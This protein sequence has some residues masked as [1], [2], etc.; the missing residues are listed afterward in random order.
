M[1]H[2]ARIRTIFMYQKPTEEQINRMEYLRR[3]C[4]DL[5]LA[6][7][8]HCPPCA[9]RQ[10]AIEHLSLVSMQANA[11]IVRHEGGK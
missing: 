7:D 1:D 4:Y 11:S 8:D 10:S 5:A 2:K 6:I 9:E 3:L